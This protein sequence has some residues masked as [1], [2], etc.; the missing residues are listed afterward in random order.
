MRKETFCV[1]N[2]ENEV[3]IPD[4]PSADKAQAAIAVALEDF[5]DRGAEPALPWVIMSMR[6][7]CVVEP[8]K[9]PVAFTPLDTPRKVK[10]AW[11]PKGYGVGYAGS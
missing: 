7:V 8:V 3:V 10:N 4:L 1:F 2:S 9:S 6:P 5:I 11:L